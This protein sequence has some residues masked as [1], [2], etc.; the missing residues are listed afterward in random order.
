MIGDAAMGSRNE[1]RLFV[2]AGFSPPARAVERDESPDGQ[3]NRCENDDA[4]QRH[5]ELDV[6]MEH[7]VIMTGDVGFPWP[8]WGQLEIDAEVWSVDSNR[9]Y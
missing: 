5:D 7:D 2:G 4:A 1:T 8:A 6:V 3:R 9:T